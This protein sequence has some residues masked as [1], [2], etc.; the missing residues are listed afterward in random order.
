MNM[1]R[2][3]LVVFLSLAGPLRA[4]ASAAQAPASPA[5]WIPRDGV[6]MGTYRGKDFKIVAYQYRIEFFPKK[7]K[8]PAVTL[9]FKHPVSVS[10][11]SADWGKDSRANILACTDRFMVYS[12]Q[13][14]EEQRLAFGGD[15]D[16]SQMRWEDPKARFPDFCGIIG[17]DGTV[18]FQLPREEFPARMYEALGIAGDGKRAAF[19]VGAYG[20]WEEPKEGSETDEGLN[21]KEIWVWEDPA[22]LRK[23]RMTEKD[24]SIFLLGELRAGRL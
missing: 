13:D 21:V 8:K 11:S 5:P 1:I 17:P 19:L 24:R 23:K 10:P 4:S 7:A 14:P 3:G 18:I 2:G 12:I 9:T 16:L 6:A 15:G 20:K 22:T